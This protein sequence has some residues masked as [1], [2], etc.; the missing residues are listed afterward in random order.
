MNNYRITCDNC[1]YFWSEHPEI[2]YGFCHEQDN[3][4]IKVSPLSACT[5]F[6]AR[7]YANN[8]VPD[9]QFKV[10]NVNGNIKDASVV[11]VY[12]DIKGNIKDCQD[13]IIINGDVKGNIHN[14][15]NVCGLLS[16]QTMTA[17]DNGTKREDKY[18]ITTEYQS[19]TRQ[20]LY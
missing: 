4:L 9:S 8:S 18:D 14:C 1:E 19:S 7:V 2:M 20:I 5:K 6:R 10:N 11:I 17:R 3:K 13:V 12:G 16:N 15:K